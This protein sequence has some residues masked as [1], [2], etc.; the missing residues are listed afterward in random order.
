MGRHMTLPVSGESPSQAEA[1]TFAYDVFV[2]HAAADEAFVQGY[3]LPELGL[4]PERILVPKKLRPGRPIIG[5]IE[6]GVCSSRVTTVVLSS[7]YMTDHWAVFGEQLAAYASVA[8]DIHGKLLPLMLEDCEL[9]THIRALVKLD[10]RDPARE[11]W[12]AESRSPRSSSRSG[13]TPVNSPPRCS[14]PSTARRW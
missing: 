6:R 7:A 12:A 5:E 1:H 10:F 14:S 9:P 4:A 3:L 2:V 13:A 8:Q 11:V